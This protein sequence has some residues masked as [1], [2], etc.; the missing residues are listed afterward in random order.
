MSRAAALSPKVGWHV[1]GARASGAAP[2]ALGE[3]AFAELHTQQHTAS[4]AS[5]VLDDDVDY[6]DDDDAADGEE[7][8]DE[9]E[10]DGADSGEEDD[11]QEGEDDD[12]VA[13]E[14]STHSGGEATWN[15]LQGYLKVEG[16]TELT[17]GVM[18]PEA[19]AHFQGAMPEDPAIAG[20]QLF[21]QCPV[22]GSLS[23]AAW[24]KA[25]QPKD[26][27]DAEFVARVRK[28]A[29][30]QRVGCSTC[31]VVTQ[32]MVTMYPNMFLTTPA[33]VERDPLAKCFAQLAD[34]PAGSV[35]ALARR[36]K[37][38]RPASRRVASR[39]KRSL[40]LLMQLAETAGLGAEGAAAEAVPP[41]RNKPKRPSTSK[42]GKRVRSS[43]RRRRRAS[44]R[45]RR[46][47]RTLATSARECNRAWGKLA[48]ARASPTEAASALSP[49]TFE[50]L[51]DAAFQDP[52]AFLEYE[53]GEKRS[54]TKNRRAIA[55]KTLWLSQVRA[56]RG[57][58]HA[59][60]PH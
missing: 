20:T 49:D 44:A 21:P 59:A 27:L 18:L 23:E 22:T 28:Q 57:V 3:A 37:K 25:V 16:R 24:W 31:L 17:E 6:D 40:L 7:D 46:K 19:K 11:L 14:R 4:L 52:L 34:L 26:A 48:H 30:S 56:E 58:L 42:P 38:K 60:A 13:Y 33:A 39:R 32:R 9:E 50:K 5:N 51:K 45:G 15:P 53:M 1:Q 10:M 47:G 41:K 8:E 43:S 35:S 55:T 29:K 36:R 2:G 54:N 12:G